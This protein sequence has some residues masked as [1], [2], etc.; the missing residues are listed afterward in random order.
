MV[1]L[2][3][4]GGKNVFEPMVVKFGGF[5]CGLSYQKFEYSFGI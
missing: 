1:M 4:M 2:I 3:R 5:V